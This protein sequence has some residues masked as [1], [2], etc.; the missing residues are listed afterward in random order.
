MSLALALA[1]L[2]ASLCFFASGAL[3]FT[4]AIAAIRPPK[5]YRARRR[6]DDADLPAEL[7]VDDVLSVPMNADAE[8]KRN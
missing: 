3:C 7:T 4:F 8:Q 5:V 1:I 2:G 6:D